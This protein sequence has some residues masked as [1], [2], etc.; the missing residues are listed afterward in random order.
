MPPPM[1]VELVAHSPKW[2]E[3]ARLEAA[4]LRE[5]IG[6]TLVTVHHIGSTSIPGIV[7]KPVLDLIPEVTGVDVLDAAKERFAA[8][9]YEWWGEYGIAGRRFFTLTDPVTATRTVHL[10]CFA[11]GSPQIARHLAF[12]DYL[13]SLREE[14]RAYET[15][16]LRA[17]D[18]HPG[19]SHA[20]SEA[21]SLWINQVEARA[22]AARR[23]Q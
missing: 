23:T 15:E 10:H 12:R 16:K 21:K 18:L 4:R 14:A 13:R 9:G 5:A 19:D 3:H 17:R 20:Y 11:T 7:A 2:A 6:N 1:R 8:L 22:L